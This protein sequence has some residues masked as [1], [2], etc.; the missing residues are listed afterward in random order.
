MP[1]IE[2]CALPQKPGVD[3]RAALATLCTAVASEFEMPAHAVWGTWQE[4]APGDYLEGADAPSVQPDST[5]PP[6]VRL[7]AF[8]GR[9]PPA[10]EKMMTLVA[11]TLSR[12]LRMEEG[13]V[14]VLFIE[15]KSGRV[16]S[17]GGIVRKKPARAHRGKAARKPRSRKRS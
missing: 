9:S 14:F 17:G 12:E 13:N 11:D 16:Y 8:E 7:F 3:R 10:I 6:I 15:G 2:V 5:H 1:I 4:F